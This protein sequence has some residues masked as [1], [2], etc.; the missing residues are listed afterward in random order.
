MRNFEKIN[1]IYDKLKQAEGF[2]PLAYEKECLNNAQ[3]VIE[4]LTKETDGVTQRYIQDSEINQA[5]SQLKDMF[6]IQLNEIYDKYKR[7]NSILEDRTIYYSSSFLQALKEE[8]KVKQSL[9]ILLLHLIAIIYE[10]D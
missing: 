9:V 1:Y 4:R 7:L 3:V 10:N 5:L 6:H 2:K 8:V